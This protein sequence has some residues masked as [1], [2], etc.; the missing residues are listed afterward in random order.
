[1]QGLVGD[2]RVD[3]YCLVKKMVVEL[4]TSVVVVVG[5]TVI[6][7]QASTSIFNNF[8]GQ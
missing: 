4:S 7:V 3:W 2:G 6:R 1:V 8:F 5:M